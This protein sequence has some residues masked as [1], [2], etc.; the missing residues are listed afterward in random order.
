MKKAAVLIFL[1]C[2]VSFA[3]HA[4]LGISK[5]LIGGLNIATLGG[6]DASSDSKT[7]MGY[8]GGIYLEFSIP[9]PLS[10]EA[11]GIYSQKGAKFSGTVI[12]LTDTYAYADIPILLKYY[13]PLP[14]L[15][16]YVYAGPSYSILLSAKRKIES[17][18]APTSDADIKDILSSNDIGA[19]VGIGGRF[20][21]VRIDARY[22]LGLST[23]D[24]NGTL[25]VYNRVAA[26]YAGIEF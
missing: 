14:M 25:K 24:K 21:I 1:L 3:A 5:G 26:L 7:L 11:E 22:N 4:Q 17:P 6:A 16:V 9:G 23:L 19:V 10:I 15:K 12:T 20:S 8:A 18:Y 13:F 2:L